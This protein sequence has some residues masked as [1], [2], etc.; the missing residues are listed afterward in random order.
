M[1]N[2]LYN[3]PQP[4]W[5][6][7]NKKWILSIM[8]EGRR[9]QF[10]SSVPGM[11]GKRECRDRC[12]EWLE[13]GLTDGN[14]KVSKAYE[15]F[16]EDYRRKHGQNEQV[17]HLV[18][19]GKNYIIPAIGSKMC[20]KVTLKDLQDI[21]NDAKPIPRTRADGSTYTECDTLSKKYLK[22][23]KG[24]LSSFVSWAAPRHYMEY[25]PMS[26]IY[27]PADAPTVG[28]DIL[29]L[30]DIE[31]LFSEPTGL[32][33]ER[34]LM[35]EV[36]TGMRPG[37]ILGLQKDDYD[38]K[39]GTIT[40]RRAINDRRKIT[41]GKNTNARRVI[42]LS[43]E[44]KRIIDE[45]IEYTDYLDSEWIF[46]NMI[47]LNA[48]QSDLRKCWKSI[49]K[50]KGLP[51]NTTPYSLRHTFYTHTEAYLPDRVIKSIFG[52]SAATD[53]HG[54][55]GN[56]IID[57]EAHEAAQRLSV[58]PLYKATQKKEKAE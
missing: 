3:I 27:I 18:S 29:Q 6:K 19:Y 28:K 57:E 45:Q 7:K 17:R 5:D 51:E 23:I 41:P 33:Y 9:K 1:A 26:Q 46:C 11:P 42:E 4:K 49:I 39:T 52:H 53:G 58:T 10:S 21:I 40:I 47:G 14:M 54:I 50:R 34:A 24:A 25:I 13:S 2:K 44:V 55:Y 31:K 20:S 48:Y 22:N 12:H 8:I 56:H 16:L 37:E 36:L 15:L 38:A 43:P 32:W 35:F 30:S